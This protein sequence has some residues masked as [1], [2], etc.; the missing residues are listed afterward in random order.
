M[1]RKIVLLFLSKSPNYIRRI[2]LLFVDIFLISV[3]FNFGLLITGEK[4]NYSFYFSLILIS[5]LIYLF[6]GQYK[7]IQGTVMINHYYYYHL[8][9]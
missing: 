1:L 2:I 3:S 4:F 5:I 6:T 8:E 7:S 9:H